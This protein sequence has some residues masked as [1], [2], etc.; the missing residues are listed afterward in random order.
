MF[1]AAAKFAVALTAAA[2]LV[3]RVQAL[4]NVT[5]AGKYLYTDSGRFYIKGIAYQ[6]QGWSER[7]HIRFTLILCA[8]AVVAD[9]NNPFGE[10][11][12]FFDPLS[13]GDA[14]NRDLPFLKN[15]GV[16]TIRAYSVNASL[17]HDA[18]MS[19]FEAAGIYTMFVFTTNE[20]LL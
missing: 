11:S 15:L 6:E 7:I 19:A 5:R 14:C 18:C 4:P 12:S 9:P 8:G 10:P 3:S 2:A 1:R 20:R 13:N 17:N 16:N